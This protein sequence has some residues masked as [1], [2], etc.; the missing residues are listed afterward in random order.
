MFDVVRFEGGDV[1][2]GDVFE[3]AGPEGIIGFDRA[4][5]RAGIERAGQRNKGWRGED[6][7]DCWLRNGVRDLGSHYRAKVKFVLLV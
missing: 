5:K 6:L 7:G 3:R 4:G 2:V 1:R